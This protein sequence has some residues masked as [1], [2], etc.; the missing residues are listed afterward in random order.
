MKLFGLLMMLF[1]HIVDDFYLQGPMAQMKSKSWW[2]KR[3]DN[4]VERRL[5][6][7]DYKIVLI[8]HAFSWTFMM[9]LTPMML[10]IFSKDYHFVTYIIMFLLN[11]LVHTLIDHAKANLRIINLLTDQFIHIIQVVVTFII[12]ILVGVIK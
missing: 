6:K 1:C 8:E 2:E 5:Y 10:M 9:M 12:F 7:N 3:M 4:V 11:W